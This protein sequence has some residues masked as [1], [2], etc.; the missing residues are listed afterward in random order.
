MT[1]ARSRISIADREMPKQRAAVKGAVKQLRDPVRPAKI[2]GEALLKRPAASAAA[3]AVAL[4]AAAVANEHHR[5]RGG[6]TYNGWWEH[7]Y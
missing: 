1:H 2:A 6:K 4:G 3:G 5:N 7:R